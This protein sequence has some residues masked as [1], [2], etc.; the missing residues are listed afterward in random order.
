M[1]LH[2][3]RLKVNAVDNLGRTVSLLLSN[4]TADKYT[5]ELGG[6][7]VNIDRSELRFAQSYLDECDAG[8][9]PTG[10]T[11]VPTTKA[12]IAAELKA[13]SAK[14]VLDVKLDDLDEDGEDESTNCT[15]SIP[16]MMTI[17]EVAGLDA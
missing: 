10:F 4:R 17:K 1:T 6:Q 7:M 5:I 15:D 3:R 11:E 8:R 16:G 12:E 9:E 14:K 13:E 2:G